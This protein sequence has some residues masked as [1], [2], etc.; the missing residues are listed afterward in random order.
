M[1]G[2][3]HRC[4]HSFDKASG[5]CCTSCCCFFRLFLCPRCL[6]IFCSSG[7]FDC[8]SATRSISF[9]KVVCYSCHLS[10]LFSTRKSRLRVDEKLV[11]CPIAVPCISGLVTRVSHYVV[12][13]V[14]V[15]PGAG[16]VHGKYPILH[17]VAFVN[18]PHS[19][20]SLPMVLC[21][22]Y[23]KQL[24]YIRSLPPDTTITTML[25]RLAYRPDDRRVTRAKQQ[26]HQSR[27][28]YH[29][30][31]TVSLDLNVPKQAVGICCFSSNKAMTS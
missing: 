26:Q 19:Q 30:I 24:Q 1:R 4:C 9:C 3:Q 7:R 15:V 11:F 2:N 6:P 14:T 25:T 5:T 31:S 23:D 22:T 21:E 20:S 10:L 13:Q 17:H 16:L 28:I 8:N 29:S 12:E 18:L 27:K